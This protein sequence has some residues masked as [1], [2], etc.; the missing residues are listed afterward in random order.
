MF[1]Q[2]LATQISPLNQVLGIDTL[3]KGNVHQGLNK[4]KYP[5][6]DEQDRLHMNHGHVNG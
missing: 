5:L 4:S 1:L 3:V 2:L 6:N